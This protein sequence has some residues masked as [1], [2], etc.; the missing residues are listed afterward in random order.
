M[1]RERKK[2]EAIFTVELQRPVVG[3]GWRLGLVGGWGSGGWW[4][5][6]QGPLNLRHQAQRKRLPPPSFPHPPVLSLGL[7]C[8]IKEKRLGPP[9]PPLHS[10]CSR[11]FTLVFVELLVSEKF[12]IYCNRKYFFVLS[13]FS[14]RIQ[15]I[16]SFS[17]IYTHAR[18]KLPTFT[19]NGGNQQ[20]HFTKR[21]AR[22]REQDGN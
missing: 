22:G 13:C 20:Q 6:R 14:C 19:Q 1:E 18:L 8:C 9:P 17:L 15:V 4:V 16:Y 21:C 11:V 10:F 5:H 3:G 12:D 2:A 7:L